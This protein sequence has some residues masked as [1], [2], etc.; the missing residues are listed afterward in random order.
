[1]STIENAQEIR[2]VNIKHEASIKSIGHLYY[3]S[4]ILMPLAGL[5]I[6]LGESS[7]GV[8]RWIT[9]SLLLVLG[10]VYFKLGGWFIKLNPK[11]KTPGTILACLGL[12]AIPLGTLINAYIL[13]LM[14]SSKGKLVFSS[15]YQVVIDAT[16]EIKY[17]T[18]KI[19]WAL[20]IILGL[21]ILL[22]IFGTIFG[23][24]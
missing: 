16:P 8:A 9:G 17:K 10:I 15:E 20:L 21:F 7:M 12:F 14:H 23:K 18:S 2:K 3:F 4:A 1:M 13:Y 24:K 6:M 22:A 5:G 11:A 19:I